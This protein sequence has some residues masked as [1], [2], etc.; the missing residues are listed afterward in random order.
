VLTLDTDHLSEF[1]RGST[2]GERL[3]RRL[4]ESGEEVGTTIVSVEEQFR[5]WLAEIHRLND[6][7]VAQIPIY[8]RLYARLEF[9]SNWEI[10]PWNE[11]AAALFTMLRK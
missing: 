4:G 9:F 6:D 10:L 5:G 8:K 7:P 3:A 1:D 2:A 11:S